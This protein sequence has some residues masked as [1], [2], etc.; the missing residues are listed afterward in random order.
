MKLCSNYLFPSVV[1][2]G[3]LLFLGS[4]LISST[5][6]VKREGRMNSILNEQTLTDK[7]SK[8]N[9]TQQCIESKNLS[10]FFVAV[11]PFFFFSLFLE[12]AMFTPLME[13]FVGSQFLMSLLDLGCCFIVN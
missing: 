2:L 4:E 6:L 9:T 5:F 12:F 11:F 1:F 3:L 10:S 8:L 13:M 7:L